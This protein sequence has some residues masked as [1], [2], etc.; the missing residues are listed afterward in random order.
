MIGEACW[1]PM[2]TV[3]F[4]SSELGDDLVV[5][6]AVQ[7]PA[8][9]TEIE[10]L[11]LLRTP[12]YERFLYPHERGVAVSFERFPDDGDERDLLQEVR[13]SGRDATVELETAARS[14]RLDVRKVDPEELA[15]MREV[16]RSMNFDGRFRL[17][18]M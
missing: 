15:E 12:K 6:F 8:D 10:S 9:P 2:D 3:S 7:T 11:T 5:S 17:I 13:Y 18:G 16:F 1:I 14:Y 4:I